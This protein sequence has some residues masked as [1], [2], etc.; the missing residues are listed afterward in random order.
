MRIF[1]YLRLVNV[2]V[3][4]GFI[5]FLL[6]ETNSERSAPLSAQIV[7]GTKSIGQESIRTEYMFG[8][9]SGRLLGGGH[10]VDLSLPTAHGRI[11]STQGLKCSSKDILPA[12]QSIT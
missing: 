5:T 10:G 4:L 11:P 7:F 3:Y 1:E 2:G 9:S 6:L 12:R 8:G